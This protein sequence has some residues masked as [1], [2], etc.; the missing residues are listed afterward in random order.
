MA[1]IASDYE[2]IEEVN[3]IEIYP[4]PVSRNLH[5]KTQQKTILTIYKK[6]KKKI[7]QHI[8]EENSTNKINVEN[9]PDGL[10]FIVDEKNNQ[11]IKFIKH[12]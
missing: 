6:K 7:D 9:Y 10:Y 4:N 11:V 2:S 12:E 3:K 1:N 8:S 5:I